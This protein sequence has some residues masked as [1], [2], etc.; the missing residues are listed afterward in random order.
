MF[1]LIIF[2]SNSKSH[3]HRSGPGNSPH[4][5]ESFL[6][7][8]S[9]MPKITEQK[10][11][12][13][14]VNFEIISIAFCTIDFLFDGTSLRTVPLLF[15]YWQLRWLI[16]IWSRLNSFHKNPFKKAWK[17]INSCNIKIK[18]LHWL[19]FL[20]LFAWNLFSPHTQFNV[21]NTQRY[22]KH[23]WTLNIEQ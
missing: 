6:W 17:T 11:R 1:S 13:K 22:Y 14:N 5:K 19:N 18:R 12:A 10:K 9:C 15:V 20:I 16:K 2:Q 3:F 7:T 4:L 21:H 23:I 8:A